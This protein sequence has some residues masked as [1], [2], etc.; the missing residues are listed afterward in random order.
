MSS[1][2]RSNRGKNSCSVDGCER[3]F[4]CSGYCG[5]H[6]ERVRKWGNPDMS[7]NPTTTRH[8]CIDC[9]KPINKVSTRCTKCNGIS[10]RLTDGGARWTN[11][12]G[13]VLLGGRWGHPNADKNGIIS[14]HKLVMAEMLGRP[15]VKGENVHHKNGVRDDNRPENL[16]L[17][18]V[19]Q[20]RGQRPEDLVAWAYEILE[21]YASDV[22]A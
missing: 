14:E 4:R 19:A 16:E 17:W 20:P 12:A 15:L 13:Y 21:R 10:R 7:H 22:A 6:Y 18:V 1:A 8:R 3:K 9:S 2:Y 11:S 5:L